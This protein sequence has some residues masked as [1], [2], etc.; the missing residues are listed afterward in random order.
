MGVGEQCLLGE[1]HV[2]ATRGA[3][4]HE[5]EPCGERLG[6]GAE[7]RGARRTQ[8]V[9]N[10]IGEGARRRGYRV[11][12]GDDRQLGMPRNRPSMIG[13]DIAAA[14]D[15]DPKCGHASVTP[16]SSVSFAKA[17]AARPNSAG[18]EKPP[19]ALKSM[20]CGSRDAKPE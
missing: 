10:E 16:R 19:L 14:H 13:P 7:L 1:L 3:D 12:R 2:R 15:R 9:D 20:R 18:P 5:V 17:R 11:N 6:Q 4:D 8:L